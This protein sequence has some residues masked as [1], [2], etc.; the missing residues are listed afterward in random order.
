MQRKEMQRKEMQR[1]IRKED[2]TNMAVYEITEKMLHF[3][4]LCLLCS[5]G[6]HR[7]VPRCATLHHAAQSRTALQHIGRAAR[8]HSV[9]LVFI[10]MV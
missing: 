7:T 4:R 8:A 10:H 1:M 2:M 9:T 6:A 5:S 3:L